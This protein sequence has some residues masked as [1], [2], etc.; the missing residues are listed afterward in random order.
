MYASICITVG[1]GVRLLHVNKAHAGFLF[2]AKDV[3]CLSSWLYSL[4]ILLFGEG[5]KSLGQILMLYK[6]LWHIF[7]SSSSHLLLLFVCSAKTLRGLRLVVTRSSPW[8]KGEAYLGLR[9]TVRTNEA[10]CVAVQ[11]ETPLCPPLLLA[12][13]PKLLLPWNCLTLLQQQSAASLSA[14]RLRFNR[15]PRDWWQPAEKHH[16]TSCSSSRKGR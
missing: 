6:G 11:T 7:Q 4:Y 3:A 8:L 13:W 9:M 16:N 12:Y 10:L 14:C 2:G 15:L 5:H 1:L